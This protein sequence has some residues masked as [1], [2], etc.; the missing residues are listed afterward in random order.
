MAGGG[1]RS[2]N[3][4]FDEAVMGDADAADS[5]ASTCMTDRLIE[6][7]GNLEAIGDL[8]QRSPSTRLAR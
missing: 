3:R 4:E 2:V 7:H 6:T 1:R 8:E 5:F